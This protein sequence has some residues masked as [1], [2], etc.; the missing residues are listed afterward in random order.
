PVFPDG[1]RNPNG[2]WSSSLEEPRPLTFSLR[3]FNPLRASK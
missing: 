1:G 2:D 3:A